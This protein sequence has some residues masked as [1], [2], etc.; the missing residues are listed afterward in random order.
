MSASDTSSESERGEALDLEV[1]KAT[2]GPDGHWYVGFTIRGHHYRCTA[3]HWTQEEAAAEI[4]RLRSLTSASQPVEGTVAIEGW[5]RKG[6]G[7]PYHDGVDWRFW[8]TDE[9]PGLPFEFARATITIRAT[10][11]PEPQR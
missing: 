7:S 10:S 9:C 11:L 4:E 6:S 5:A 2:Q 3:P 8:A 1:I